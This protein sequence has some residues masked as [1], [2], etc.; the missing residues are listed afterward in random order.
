M[1]SVMQGK[2]MQCHV[3]WCNGMKRNVCR[4]IM[5]YTASSNTNCLGMRAVHP[6][7]CFQMS[8]FLNYDIWDIL[9]V[10][11]KFK[12]A[13]I[14]GISRNAWSNKMLS[15]MVQFG[16]VVLKTCYVWI[17]VFLCRDLMTSYKSYNFRYGGCIWQ[18]EQVQQAE[19]AERAEQ[20]EQAEAGAK[21]PS[22]GEAFHARGLK[23]TVQSQGW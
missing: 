4:D 18:F 21:E 3:M 10:S 13:S 15:R 7:Y 14:A 1:Y 6:I 2:S 8:D 19:R 17:T 11:H 9:E 23:L 20:A 16:T 12:Q 22:A 5:G